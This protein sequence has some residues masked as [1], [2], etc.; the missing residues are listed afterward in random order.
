MT[1]LDA[2]FVFSRD[3]DTVTVVVMNWILVDGTDQDGWKF[4]LEG[5][6]PWTGRGRGGLVS[7][8]T[9]LLCREQVFVAMCFEVSD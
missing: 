5:P 6:V 4:W 3:N 1:C 7:G 2:S 8:V 9:S